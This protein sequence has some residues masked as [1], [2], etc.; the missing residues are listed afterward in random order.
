MYLT[1][2][3]NTES[4]TDKNEER[5]RFH[6]NEQNK[7]TVKELNKTEIGKRFHKMFKAMVKKIL[8]G[9]EKR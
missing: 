9:L 5:N 4:K 7:I 6:M 1:Y 2:P 3:I 8:T